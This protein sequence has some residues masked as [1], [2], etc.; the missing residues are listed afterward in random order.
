L[1]DGDKTPLT[2]TAKLTE[3]THFIIKLH[4]PAGKPKETMMA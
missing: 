2:L 1:K 4:H 3:V